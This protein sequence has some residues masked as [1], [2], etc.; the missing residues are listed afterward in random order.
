MGFNKTRCWRGIWLGL[1]FFLK[2]NWRRSQQGGRKTSGEAIAV[3]QVGHD[4]TWDQAQELER[5]RWAL[6]GWLSWP[7]RHPQTPKHCRAKAGLDGGMRVRSEEKVSRRTQA[8]GS[9]TWLSE[10]LVTDIGNNGRGMGTLGFVEF[11]APLWVPSGNVKLSR[12]INEICAWG[13]NS[14]PQCRDGYY[15]RLKDETAKSDIKKERFQEWPKIKSR[16]Q[17]NFLSL[18]RGQNLRKV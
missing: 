15:R 17:S 13:I 18:S 11:Q 10:M 1:Q 12:W 5:S 7:E 6:A 14:N 9:G 3:F 16:K 8:S 4:G 2:K